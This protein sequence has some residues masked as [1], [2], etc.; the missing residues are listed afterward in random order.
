MKEKYFDNRSGDQT[1]LIGRF[2]DKYR[3]GQTDLCQEIERNVFGCVYGA[4]SWTN[5][6]EADA[7]A[8]RL[9]LA[10]G[11][12]LLDVGAGTGWPSIYWAMETGCDA[13]CIDL[14]FEG[15]QVLRER[16]GADGV[17]GL[18]RPQRELVA[19]VVSGTNGCHY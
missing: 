11:K 15:L 19:V 17:G 18:T 14:P 7:V 5:R 6:A 8:K 1:E 4:T 12:R 2:S 9:G 10:P 13:V 16:A 3:H